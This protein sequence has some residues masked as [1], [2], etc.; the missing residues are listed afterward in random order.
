MPGYWPS[1]ATPS[2]SAGASRCRSPAT[3]RPTAPWPCPRTASSGASCCTASRKGSTAS[4]T[5]GSSPTAVAPGRCRRCRTPAAAKRRP[6]PATAPRK[7]PATTGQPAR[8]AAR[9]P[10]PCSRSR[11][12][13]AKTRKTSWTRSG[14]ARVSAARLAQAARHDRNAGRNAA[15]TAVPGPHRHRSSLRHRT[16]SHDPGRTRPGARIPSRIPGPRHLGETPY[17]KIHRSG[18]HPAIDLNDR[19][20][21]SARDNQARARLRSNSLSVGV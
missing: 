19:N 21:L 4:G 3:G 10:R 12:G 20:P 14:R 6:T 16:A 1:T 18:R 5:S 8:S 7:R 2:P 17:R 9:L 15:K 13:R 11:S